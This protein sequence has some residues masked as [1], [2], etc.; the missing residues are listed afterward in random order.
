MKNNVVFIF[1]GVVFFVVIAL[2]VSSIYIVHQTE[3]AMI[4]QFGEPK[5]VVQEP[6]IKFKI[7][8]I[9]NVVYY[10]NRLLE[11]EPPSE[12]VLLADQKRIVVDTFSRFKIVDPLLF[13]QS[14]LTEDFARQRLSDAI[15]SSLRDVLG[16]ETLNTLL[17]PSRSEIMAKIREQVNL[18]TSAK[19]GVNMVDVRIRR[20]DLPEQTSQSIYARMRSEREKEAKEIRAEGTELAQQIRA[21]ADKEKT[22]L[23]A[24]AQKKSEII[25]GE[26]DKEATKIWGNAANQDKEFYA[27]YRSLNAYKE[28][29]KDD[30]T[31]MLIAPDSEFFRYFSKLPKG[32]K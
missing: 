28:A 13:Y 4:L 27:F 14:V 3:Q 16:N 10:D 25:R 9:Q 12:E 17:A 2:L 23:L 8:F 7:P 24:E 29:M 22:V 26:G 11:V 20:A 21:K 15:I 31:S 32:G 19:F 1:L 6:G 18:K 30:N 5:R